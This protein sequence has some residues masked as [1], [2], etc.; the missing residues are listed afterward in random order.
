MD[1]TWMTLWRTQELANFV[2]GMK[3]APILLYHLAI[4]YVRKPLRLSSGTTNIF[5][6]SMDDSWRTPWITFLEGRNLKI[7]TLLP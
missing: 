5:L 7:E 4:Y 1:D 3:I 6:I 2:G